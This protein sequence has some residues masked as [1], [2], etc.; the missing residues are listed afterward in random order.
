MAATWASISSVVMPPTLAMELPAPWR[1][2]AVNAKI[3]SGHIRYMRLPTSLR[4]QRPRPGLPGFLIGRIYGL[5][6]ILGRHVVFYRPCQRRPM[7]APAKI[8]V[9]PGSPMAHGEQLGSGKKTGSCHAKAYRRSSSGC[10]STA[11]GLPQNAA[12]ASASAAACKNLDHW[13]GFQRL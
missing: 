9:G 2:V 7:I 4:R 10:L 13:K 12:M 1:A 8:A 5:T 6:G 3:G 11:H